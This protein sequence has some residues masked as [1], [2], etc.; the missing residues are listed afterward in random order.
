MGGLS[1]PEDV[2]QHLEPPKHT[3][4]PFMYVYPAANPAAGPAVQAAPESEEERAVQKNWP[5][6]PRGPLRD[7]LDGFVRMHNRAPGIEGLRLT[8]NW[9]VPA[10]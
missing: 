2:R 10:I 3:T 4:L 8:P 6:F 9:E 1:S 5:M 7:Y